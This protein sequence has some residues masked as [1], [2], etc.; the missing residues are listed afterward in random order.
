MMV[1]M[2]AAGW[3]LIRWWLGG[4]RTFA[5]LQWSNSDER[6]RN[7]IRCVM[8]VMVVVAKNTVSLDAHL[9]CRGHILMVMMTLGPLCTA[10]GRGKTS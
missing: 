2:G 10:A 6:R 3:G 9:L 5:W 1:M 8:V 7:G 4:R